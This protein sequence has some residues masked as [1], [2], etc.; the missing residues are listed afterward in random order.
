MIDLSWLFQ[1][2]DTS[3]VHPKAKEPHVIARNQ[4]VQY[5]QEKGIFAWANKTGYWHRNKVETTMSRFITKFDDRLSSRTVQA[6]K[7][8]IVIKCHILNVLM[9]A[10]DNPWYSAA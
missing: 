5:Y 8:E 7:N 10:N 4:V 6:Q 3:V 2:K 1:P 9:A